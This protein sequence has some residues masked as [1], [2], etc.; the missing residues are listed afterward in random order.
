MLNPSYTLP[1]RKT[2]S[3]NIIPRLYETTKIEVQD[4]INQS[5]AVCLITN[6]W[7]SSKNVSFMAI[8]AHFFDIN[9][10]LKSFCLDCTV[11]SHAKSQ[12]HSR[13]L[14]AQSSWIS[15]TKFHSRAKGLP[16][17]NLSKM[18]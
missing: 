6:C 2:I 15:Q 13:V 1:S 8:T 5:M 16:K 17:L 4:L 12:E 14:Q 9:T 7:T 10:Q 3:N 18:L 11:L